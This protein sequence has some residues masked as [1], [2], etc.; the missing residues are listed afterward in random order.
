MKRLF[1]ISGSSGV[2]KG[3]VIKEF[4]KRNPGFKLSVSCTT[5]NKRPGEI[6]GESYHFISRDEFKKGIEDNDFLEWAEFS[7]NYYGTRKSNI[8][9]A[10]KNG[11]NIIL[12]IETQGAM[13][14]KKQITDAVLI[15][16]APP[17]FEE[18][19]KRLEGRQT[20]NPEAIR[21]RLAQAER[22]QND[23]KNY[24]HIIINDTIQNAVENLEKIISQYLI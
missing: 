1:V 23:S 20:E 11:E 19:K 6:D 2:G 12:E 22:E 5:R 8:E 16:I 24:D 7:N 3:T 21:T 18:L 17:S 15:F 14:V 13:Q 4:L 10:L 9:Q